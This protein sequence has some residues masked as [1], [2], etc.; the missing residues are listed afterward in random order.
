MTKSKNAWFGLSHAVI[1]RAAEPVVYPLLCLSRGETL[2]ALRRFADDG[3]V[4]PFASAEEAFA[5]CDDVHKLCRVCLRG[6]GRYVCP[7][8]QA[9]VLPASLAA[10]VAVGGAR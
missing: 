4:G 8:C 5:A 2:W 7:A 10:S 6:R 9:A 1:P 3:I